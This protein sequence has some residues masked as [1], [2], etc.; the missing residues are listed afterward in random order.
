MDEILNDFE[1]ETQGDYYVNVREFKDGTVEAVV[2]TVRPMRADLI[3]GSC[4]GLSYAAGCRAIGESSSVSS[5]R[6]VTKKEEISE[7]DRAKNQ[8][9]AVRRAKQGIRWLCKQFGADRLFT[10]SY[11]KNQDDRE[12]VKAHFK[13]FLRLVRKGWNGQGGIPDWHYVAVLE[14]QERGAYH[15]HC[16]VKGWQKITFLRAAWY[17]ALGGQGNETGEGTPGQ[18][19]V[20]NPDKAKW[21]HTGREWKSRKLSAYLT[22]Y[23][24]KT[25]DETSAEKKRYWHTKDI[26]APAN[27]RFILGAINIVGAIQEA[28]DLLFFQCGLKS[29]FEMWLSDSEDCFWLSGQ[30]S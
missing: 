6:Y 2:K 30:M 17:K 24:Q 13:K 18:V 8:S 7:F 14:R 25:F 22:K 15:I 29:G 26:K 12:E 4:D 10:L 23:L 16:A 19:D 9:R 20:T 21:G 3:L 11:R 1:A 27:Q 28:V 5:S